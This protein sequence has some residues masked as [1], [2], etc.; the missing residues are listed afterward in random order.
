MLDRRLFTPSLVVERPRVAFGDGVT[1][2]PTSVPQTLW[3][4]TQAQAASV[5]PG[6]RILHPDRN[7]DAVQAEVD[8]IL[9]ETG[10]Q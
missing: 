5:D 9:V 6:V 2:D 8:R 1:E 4:L 7:D 10:Q 3:L